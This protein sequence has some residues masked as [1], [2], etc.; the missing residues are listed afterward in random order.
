M[1]GIMTNFTAGDM[2][3]GK[4]K[5]PAKK[6]EKPAK[7]EKKEVKVEKPV[8]EDAQLTSETLPEAPEAETTGDLE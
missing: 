7:K 5:A 1:S 3:G 4:G 8:V 2:L 6:A